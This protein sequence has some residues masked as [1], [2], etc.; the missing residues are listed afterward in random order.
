M[1]KLSIVNILKKTAKDAEGKSDK[2][3]NA[4]SAVLKLKI[5]VETVLIHWKIVKYADTLILKIF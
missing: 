1:Q 3:N 2:A 5:Y 4:R